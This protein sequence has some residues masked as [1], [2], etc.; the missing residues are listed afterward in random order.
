MCLYYI[1]N[2]KWQLRHIQLFL[3]NFR[4]R[5]RGIVY[6]VS[7]L[8]RIVVVIDRNLSFQE[9]EFQWNRRIIKRAISRAARGMRVALCYCAGEST[10]DE[11]D[12]HQSADCRKSK[13]VKCFW[14]K[15]YSFLLA[16]MYTNTKKRQRSSGYSYVRKLI[17]LCSVFNSNRNSSFE[18]S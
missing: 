18:I 8:R 7:E 16:T 11:L 15:R 9:S 5:S 2:G 14:H 10:E 12:V 6:L 3:A 1:V 17:V 4:G 13:V